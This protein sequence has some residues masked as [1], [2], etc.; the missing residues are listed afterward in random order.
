M[1]W[2][3]LIG[4]VALLGA[5]GLLLWLYGNS[6]ESVGRLAERNVWKDAT[7]KHDKEVREI[8]RGWA[9]KL[10]AAQTGYIERIET[11]RPVRVTNREVVTRYAETPAG[12]VLCLAPD[13]V[14]G[15]EQTRAALFPTYSP[16]AASD[17]LG[18]VL[19]DPTEDPWWL[20]D[21]GE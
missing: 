10:A 11:I 9:E 7:I 8:E 17:G 21:G 15:I 13:R 1:S 16:K 4:G 3:R 6:R 14:L 18:A 19:A 20:N 2:W 5:V 12:R